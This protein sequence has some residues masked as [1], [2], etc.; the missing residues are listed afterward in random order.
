MREGRERGRRKKGRR[1]DDMW[2]PQVS[3]SPC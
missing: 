2:A 1:L 3:G